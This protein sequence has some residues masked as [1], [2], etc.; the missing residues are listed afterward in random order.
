MLKIA[1]MLLII[2]IFLFPYYWMVS[3]SLEPASAV[4]EGKPHW[5]PQDFTIANY[6]FIF[7]LS[8]FP[9]WVFNSLFI[10][11]MAVVLTCLSASMAGYVLAKR[12]FPGN[13]II[14]FLMIATMAIPVNTIILPRFLVMKRL[15]LI[16]TYPSMFLIYMAMPFG[17]FLMR[18]I[19]STI[20]EEIIESGMI[21]GA[22]EWQIYWRLIVPMARPGIIALGMFT[23]VACYGD[24]FWQLLMTQTESMRT[25]PLAIE[26]FR[27]GMLTQ[28][29]IPNIQLTMAAAL[30][31]SLPLLVLYG[32]FHK[33][34]IE[35]P[36]LG[37]IK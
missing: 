30:M 25:L 31:A 3:L 6:L 13:K 1:I 29:T 21:D 32:L 19:M 17:I 37:S 7:N 10:P 14:F 12:K 26:F 34:F 27:Q 5:F 23:F 8:W 35:G 24:Y 33:Y 15:G 36:S 11:G 22:S 18:Q 16:N 9:K 28:K 2:V 4:L 20:P